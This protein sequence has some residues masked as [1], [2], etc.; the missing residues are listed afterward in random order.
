MVTPIQ[1]F[2]PY[3]HE[4]EEM[5]YRVR[6]ILDEHQARWIRLSETFP[7]ESSRDV[8]GNFHLSLR[9][10][11]SNRRLNPWSVE[12]QEGPVLEGHIPFLRE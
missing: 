11:G 10:A 8:E 2:Y 7:E 12:K 5:P 6:D 9:L 4:S 3:D 1:I